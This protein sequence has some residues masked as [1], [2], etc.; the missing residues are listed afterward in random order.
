LAAVRAAIDFA[1]AT[2]RLEAGGWRQ[3]NRRGKKRWCRTR[4]NG[5]NRQVRP[6]IYAAGYGPAAFERHWTAKELLSVF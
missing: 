4:R 2:A 5:S 1:T 3:G 6:L